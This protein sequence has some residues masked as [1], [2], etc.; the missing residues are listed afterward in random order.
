[1]TDALKTFQAGV[2]LVDKPV[3]PTSFRIVQQVRRALRIKKVGHAGTLDPF[4]SGLLIVCAG[5][6]ATRNISRLM[7]GEKEYAATLRL[8]IETDTHDVEGKIVAQ[9]PVTGVDREGVERCLAG[10]VGEQMQ[11]PP[12][13]SAVKHKGK[14]LY[15]YARQ[16]VEVSKPPRPIVIRQ[17]QCLDFAGK[18][19]SIRVVCGKGTYIRTLAADIGTALGCGAHLTALRRLRSGVFSVNDALPGSGLEEP[20]QGRTLLF[21]HMLTVEQVFGFLRDQEINGNQS[22]IRDVI[23]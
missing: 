15:H 7:D 23:A 2:F 3:G 16:G 17:I 22:I 1:M 19:V 9:R 12:R 18:S 10:F 4:A 8:G 5:R 11:T 13:Y 20:E 21:D 6:P 14:P